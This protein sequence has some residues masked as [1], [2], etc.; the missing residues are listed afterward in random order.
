MKWMRYEPAEEL[1]MNSKT[2]N[3]SLQTEYDKTKLLQGLCLAARSIA[4]PGILKTTSFSIESALDIYVKTGNTYYLMISAAQM[5]LI[6][7]IRAI[8]QYMG[9]FLMSESIRMVYRGKRFLIFNFL[10]TYLVLFL[11]YRGIYFIHGIRFDFGLT[12]HIM[13]L[14]VFALTYLNLFSIPLSNKIFVLISMQLCFQWLDEIPVISKYGFGRGNLSSLIK[15]TAVEHGDG[16]TLSFYAAALG[17]SFLFAL[18]IQIRLLY[19][20]HR[21]KTMTEQNKQMTEQLYQAQIDAL[22]LRSASEVQSLVHDLKSPL[23]AMQGLISLSEMMESDHQIR[24][25]LGRISASAEGM[26]G[27][28]SD[29]LYEEHRELCQTDELFR[30]I[31]AQAQ[32]GIPGNI[33]K[34]RNHAKSA[35]LQVNRIRFSR[36]VINIIQNAYRA[37]EEKPDG[38]ID[39]SVRELQGTVIIRIWDN[40]NGIP[41]AIQEKIWQKGYSAAG[42]TGIGLDFVKQVIENHGGDIKIQ[43][44]EGQYTS[45]EIWMKEAA[46]HGENNTD[47]G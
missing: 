8:P 24:E 26:S 14:S 34:Y 45:F 1:R 19:K 22:K 10:L 32:A 5:V 18:L 21:L 17:C 7:C 47:M 35:L 31:L 16:W 4:L 41:E 9:A 46:L 40:G 6:N 28:I 12:A 15:E 30:T 11:V 36:A 27:M 2:V 39:I 25:Y 20:E 3:I 42:S 33:I 37:V 38:L 43:S 23:T 44:E 13:I 29:I